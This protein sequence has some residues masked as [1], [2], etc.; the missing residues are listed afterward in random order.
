M[1]RA[2]VDNIKNFF[3]WWSDKKQQN[4]SEPQTTQVTWWTAWQWAWKISIERYTPHKTQNVIKKAVPNIDV[5]LD[6]QVPTNT[7]NNINWIDISSSWLWNLWIK[8]SSW[9]NVSSWIDVSAWATTWINSWLFSSNLLSWATLKDNW[10]E[11]KE[12]ELTDSTTWVFD[13]L[14]EVYWFFKSLV[15][16]WKEVAETAIDNY[17]LWSKRQ[18]TVK[19]IEDD[20]MSNQANIFY[21]DF[22]DEWTWATKAWAEQEFLTKLAWIQNIIYDDTWLYS[23]NDKQTALDEFVT[24]TIPLLKVESTWYMKWWYNSNKT[25]NLYYWYNTDENR[26]KFK[27]AW[28][29]FEVS[30]DDVLD[31]VDKYI[32]NAQLASDVKEWWENMNFSYAFSD[33][34]RTQILSNMINNSSVNYTSIVNSYVDDWKLTWIASKWFIV[35]ADEFAQTQ[36]DRALMYLETPLAEYYKVKQKEADWETLTYWERNVL[37]AWPYLEALVNDYSKYIWD[38]IDET[39]K[40]WYS[41]WEII[42]NIKNIDWLSMKDYWVSSV[43]LNFKWAMDALWAN[44]TVLNYY[45]A[46][47]L[48]QLVWNATSNN[49]W[50]WKW[51]VVY[52]WWKMLQSWIWRFWFEWWEMTS[53][54]YRN[55]LERINTNQWYAEATAAD[56]SNISLINTDKEWLWRTM[57]EYYSSFNENVPEIAW[58]LLADRELTQWTKLVKSLLSRGNKSLKITPR[59]NSMLRAANK[60]LKTE[61]TIDKATPW[62][63]FRTW[64]RFEK[65]WK[66]S[67]KLQT[68]RNIENW[69]NWISETSKASWLKNTSQWVKNFLRNWIDKTYWLMNSKEWRLWWEVA[70]NVISNTIADQ[71]LDALMSYY[72]TEAYSPASFWISVWMSMITEVLSP[73]MR[74]TLWN[75]ASRTKVANWWF[76][77]LVTW[78]WSNTWSFVRYIDWDDWTSKRFDEI[79]WMLSNSWSPM[80]I[81]NLKLLSWSRW[82]LLWNIDSLMK[83]LWV[84][85]ADAM[86]KFSKDILFD[87]IRTRQEID[88]S[89]EFYKRLTTLV[90]SDKTN[91]SDVVKYVLWISW[92]VEV[93]PFKSIIKFKDWDSI[94]SR[95]LI[96]WKWWSKYDLYL[97][98]IDWQF[99][100]QLR[101]WFDEKSIR[102]I[103]KI[104]WY[105]W[106]LKDWDIN[107]NMF[108]Y[109]KKTKKY[110]INQNW[111]DKFWLNISDY[112]DA[113]KKA[114]AIEAVAKND[115]KIVMKMLK[116]LSDKSWIWLDTLWELTSWGTFSQIRWVLEEIMC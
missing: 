40:Q 112:T 75:I 14:W 72:D 97:D 104:E 27:N 33:E 85:W 68:T 17:E 57:K 38:V 26:E 36:N 4:I 32:Y 59:L 60:A 58:A 22:N 76:V 84:Q 113:L 114:D 37:K 44:S 35:R 92:E 111:A 96:N 6:E 29:S 109:D 110:Y 7:N 46:L 93:W 10:A 86:W 62:T 88:K 23:D 8:T 101:N 91:I 50:D 98:R 41:D 77:N 45:S 19:W 82:K 24:S 55:T 108:E 80:T 28:W 103:S 64:W 69:I 78:D 89:S 70:K 51:W 48:I 63:S 56:L 47:D 83:Q 53:Y 12:Q 52:S 106:V 1:A 90:N 79:V 39:A 13:T 65:F 42:F 49:Y 73:L 81:D 43:L 30:R 67:W 16:V 31:F 71:R 20:P 61:E 100:N 9:S 66:F 87:K 11:K 116:K 54:L 25:S 94:Q 5:S 2:R 21:V 105:D 115:E 15:W 99:I 95:Y 102:E 3:T 34:S 18:Y 107:S 74:S